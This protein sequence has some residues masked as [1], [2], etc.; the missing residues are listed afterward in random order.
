M[1]ASPPP[2]YLLPGMTKEFPVYARLLPLLPDAIVVDFPLP[3]P[4]E[5]L[6]AYAE[7]MAHSVPAFSFVA[8]VSFG[9]IVAL[10][11]ARIICPLG[12]ILISSIRDPQELPPWYRVCRVI[13]GQRCS[14][15]MKIMGRL[16][17]WVPRSVCT[18][19]TLRAT[20]LAGPSGIWHRWATAAVLDW[21]PKP[22][23]GTCR[24]FRST[25]VRTRRFPFDTL[26]LMSGSPM[27]CTLYPFH[28]REKLQLPYGRLWTTV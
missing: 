17:T 25:A 20:K 26:T 7:R 10:E 28:T 12:C 15:A 22:Q 23:I 24:S 3:R 16:A 6:V 21:R 8:G 27:D 19:S 2:I 13:G 11:I 1:D 18:T 5:S 14:V 4:Q 9:G